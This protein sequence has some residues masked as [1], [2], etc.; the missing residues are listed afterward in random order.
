MREYWYLAAL[1]SVALVYAVHLYARR[2]RANG[3]CSPPP[4][5]PGDHL[6]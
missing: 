2:R 4:A 1:A 5:E 6:G 3:V